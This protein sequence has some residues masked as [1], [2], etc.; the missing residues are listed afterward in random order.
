MEKF[1]H[2]MDV[3]FFEEKPFYSKLEIQGER[4]QNEF[5]LWNFSHT[6][7]SLTEPEVTITAGS[8]NTTTTPEVATSPVNPTSETETKI[9]QTDKPLLVFSRREKIRQEQEPPTFTRKSQDF[10]QIPEPTETH[11][12]NTFSVPPHLDSSNQEITDINLPIVVRKGVRSGTQHPIG[13]FV[14]YDRLSSNYRAFETTLDNTQ[15]PRNIQ[16]ALQH[17]KWAATVKEEVL[18]LKKNRTWEFSNL[19]KGKKPV[20][21]K[22]IFSIKYNADGSV[23]IYKARLVAKGFTQSYGIDY[24]ETFAPVAKLNSVRVILSLAANL[25]WPLHQL[26]IKNVFLNG[27]LEEEVYMTIPQGLENPRTAGK[28]C[29]LRKSLYGPNNLLRHGLKD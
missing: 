26:D 25:D 22:W 8:V 27:E 14:S 15:I 16:E 24:E 23:T 2:S 29:K 1:Y 17:Q 7:H 18:A 13:N 5:Q 3:T 20:G 12:G 11:Q 28:V 4:K 10:V 6:G 9:S 19:P 21:C